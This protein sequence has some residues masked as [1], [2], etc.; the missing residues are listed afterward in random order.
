MKLSTVVLIVSIILIGGCSTG[1]ET[2]EKASQPI[3]TNTEKPLKHGLQKG[4]L[5]PPYSAITTKG[6][7]LQ[8]GSFSGPVLLYFFATW[9][10]Y[11]ME[12]LTTLSSI[13]PEYEEDVNILA[14]DMDLKED[15]ELID[16]YAARF[17]ALEG[18]W[19]TLGNAK[20]LSAYQ[21]KYTTTKYAIGKDGTVLYAGSG[22]FT[23]EQWRILLDA[24]RNS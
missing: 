16:S 15:A 4:D 3:N 19:F 23:K 5:A 18:V 6:A 21:V 8:N 2:T 7:I 11:C 13:Y 12:D 22:A 24:M 9:C 20:T 10:P 14:I 17:P 1:Q